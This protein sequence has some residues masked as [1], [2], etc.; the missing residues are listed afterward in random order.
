[1]KKILEFVVFKF[2]K[3]DLQCAHQQANL[4]YGPLTK[5]RFIK[6]DLNFKENG[7]GKDI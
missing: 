6:K 7:V 3:Q 2:L 4:D 1:M 5:I